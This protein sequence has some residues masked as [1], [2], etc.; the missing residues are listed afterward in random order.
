MTPFIASLKSVLD[1]AFGKCAKDAG[2]YIETDVVLY[3]EQNSN[4]KIL[5]SSKISGA[6]VRD[7]D[8][9]QRC[10]HTVDRNRRSGSDL[11]VINAVLIHKD[12]VL[13]RYPYVFH[14]S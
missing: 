1:I 4:D 10:F 5:G 7:P 13:T 6:S 11:L 2:L 9:L 3:G 12:S 14:C 8:G